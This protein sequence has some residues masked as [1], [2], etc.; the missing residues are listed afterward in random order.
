MQKK[1]LRAI[2]FIKREEWIHTLLLSWQFWKCV[3]MQVEYQVEYLLTDYQLEVVYKQFASIIQ[4]DGFQPEKYNVD[5]TLTD[6]KI[7]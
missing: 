2:P 1:E 7:K 3:Q 4:S 6:V 5:I